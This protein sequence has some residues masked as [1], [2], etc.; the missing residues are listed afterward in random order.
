VAGSVEG[1][2]PAA[3]TIV[4]G[5]GHRLTAGRPVPDADIGAG[6][7]EMQ[8]AIEHELA[9]RI[10]GMLAAIVG[11]DKAIAHVAV[12]LDLA[13]I[14]RTE[15]SCDPDRTAV[16]P[17]RTTR[18]QTAVAGTP[19]GRNESA[20]GAEAE[21]PASLRR[22]ESQDWEVSKVVSHSV[23]PP[24]AVKQLSIAVLVDGTYTEAPDG[25]RV[26]SPRPA[27]ELDRL[28][29]LVKGAVGYSETRGDRIE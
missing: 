27:A 2:A 10:E 9:A 15:E 17:Q 7:L 26:F 6:A 13:R 29:E 4:D 22:D 19:A 8:A 28:R 20:A 12:T 1:L 25:K 16:R 14:E 11:R 18:E 21:G 23:A 24:G 5:S 3:V